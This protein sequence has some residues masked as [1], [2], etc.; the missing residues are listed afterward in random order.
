[1]A[2]VLAVL[3]AA[4]APLPALAA[5]GPSWKAAGDTGGHVDG[6]STLLTDGTVL[7]VGGRE[8]NS[9][10]P[11]GVERYDP[12]SGSWTHA[13]ATAAP[14]AGQAAVRLDDG[15][16]LVVG[17]SSPNRPGP[18]SAVSSAELYNV[19]TLN[20][21]A[22]APMSVPRYH[23]TL[24]VL[25]DGRVLV[26]G[27]GSGGDVVTASAETYDPAA[28]RWSAVPPM[29]TPRVDASALLLRTGQVL[30]AGGEATANQA[31]SLDSAELFDYRTN[32]WAAAPKMHSPHAAAISAVLPDGTGLVAGGFDYAGGYQLATSASEYYN[33]IVNRWFE[34]PPLN[35]ARGQAG[36]A[37]LTDGSIL[38]VGGDNRGSVRTQSTGEALNWRSR[39]WTLLPPTGRLRLT[40]IVT[41]LPLGRA[42]VVGGG[43]ELTAQLYMPGTVPPET[44]ATLAAAVGD[45]LPL[46]GLSALLLLGVLGQLA[47]RS[48]P[49]AGGGR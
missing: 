3:F 19:R 11:S 8:N 18:Y 15:R 43:N 49:Q 6:T 34:G 46:V 36:F 32:R 38:V 25:P 47:W 37:K 23:P 44:A 48:R 4:A 22:A 2:A 28:D 9:S 29:S 7:V 45:N 10:Q 26:A 24:T 21:T 30:V 42:L 17:G 5:S 14:R 20:W 27:G 16:V 40:P 1:V 41:A 12:R 31:A 33:P 13:A 39:R 35:L